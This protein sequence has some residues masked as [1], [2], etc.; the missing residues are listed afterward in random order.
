M[1]SPCAP[2][3]RSLSGAAKI[4][5]C[6]RPRPVM[7]PNASGQLQLQRTYQVETMMSALQASELDPP[8]QRSSKCRQCAPPCCRPP[9]LQSTTSLGLAYTL[10]M[11]H[12]L[13]QVGVSML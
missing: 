11:H 6:C 7:L 5:H 1:Q 9:A 8:A 3:K 4:C 10:G 12:P 13:V 2:E